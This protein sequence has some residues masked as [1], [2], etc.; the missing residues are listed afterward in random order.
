[1]SKITFFSVLKSNLKC[2]FC[3]KEHCPVQYMPERKRIQTYEG[4][5][6][7][8]KCEKDKKTHKDAIFKNDLRKR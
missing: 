5:R 7:I 6:F 8:T 3:K 1:M 4:H 2:A